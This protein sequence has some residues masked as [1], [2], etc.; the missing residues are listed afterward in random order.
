[1]GAFEKLVGV[2][3]HDQLIAKTAVILKALYD[4]DLV[5]EETFLEWGKKVRKTSISIFMFMS[6]YHF[7]ASF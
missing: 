3:Y 7:H 4:L 6:V 5:D 1:M 2:E